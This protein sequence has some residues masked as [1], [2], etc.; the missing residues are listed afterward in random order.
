MFTKINIFFW[1]LLNIIEKQI[2]SIQIFLQP[3][4]IHSSNQTFCIFPECDGNSTNP[5]SNFQEINFYFHHYYTQKNISETCEIFLIAPHKDNMSIKNEYLTNPSN[6]NNYSDIPNF[7]WNNNFSKIKIQPFCY[8]EENLT[9]CPRAS[10]IINSPM[11][12]FLAKEEFILE[13]VDL[14]LSAANFKT[15]FILNNFALTNKVALK[16]KNC[17]IRILNENLNYFAVGEQLISLMGLNMNEVEIIFKNI[18]IEK[19]QFSYGFLKMNDKINSCNILIEE[20]FFRINLKTNEFA[21]FFLNGSEFQGVLNLNHSFITINQNCFLFVQSNYSISFTNLSIIYEKG[22]EISFRKSHLI[23]VLRNNLFSILNSSINF[24]NVDFLPIFKIGNNNSLILQKSKIKSLNQKNI[25]TNIMIFDSNKQ[26]LTKNSLFLLTGDK[27]KFVFNEIKIKFNLSVFQSNQIVNFF[28]ILGS[29]NMVLMKNVK[30]FLMFDK[31]N[32]IENIKFLLTE[33]KNISNSLILHHLEIFLPTQIKNIFFIDAWNNT[34]LQM[35]EVF[36]NNVKHYYNSS[37]LCKSS[38]FVDK[39]FNCNPCNDAISKCKSCVIGKS[40]EPICLISEDSETNTMVLIIM[41]V[42]IPVGT[43][44]AIIICCF[45]QHYFKKQNAEQE[46]EPDTPTTD[47]KQY[48]SIENIPYYQSF[49]VN[50]NV[51]QSFEGHISQI[52]FIS[53]KHLNIELKIESDLE[54]DHVEESFEKK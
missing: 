52:G 13:N 17:H 6:F 1:I 22:I 35:I 42:L 14:I 31:T 43:I 19:I 50:N 49:A 30:Y 27:N 48:C 28:L 10:I 4:E 33:S 38:H 29:Y 32:S 2:L 5:F 7:F 20:S 41:S 51:Y 54:E 3:K 26:R 18:I 11:F 8:L 47:F 9:N 37:F 16:I 25:Q 34:L 15:I 21:F 40:F 45:L 12:S 24:T 46:I 23:T 53:E 39:N 44:L 36:L